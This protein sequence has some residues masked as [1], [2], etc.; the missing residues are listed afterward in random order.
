MLEQMRNLL[1]PARV[2]RRPHSDDDSDRDAARA[3][4]GAQHDLE[5][6]GE[7]KHLRVVQARRAERS[8][9]R[10]VERRAGERERAE[11]R[12]TAAWSQ[13]H[14]SSGSTQR[15]SSLL[16]GPSGFWIW[17]RWMPAAVGGAASWISTRPL[18][19]KV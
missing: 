8:G 11:K 12:D 13:R 6:V 15:G 2:A 18:E 1:L 16:R 10:G 4:A 14:A 7:A 9:V 19:Q 17:S 5:A 3:R